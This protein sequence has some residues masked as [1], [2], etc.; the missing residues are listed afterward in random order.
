MTIAK[1]ASYLR[2]QRLEYG[3]YWE[4]FLLPQMGG[5]F[6]MKFVVILKTSSNFLLH[7]YIHTRDWS[8]PF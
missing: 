3:C 2:V 1:L 5:S 8:V 4:P 6:L 7:T